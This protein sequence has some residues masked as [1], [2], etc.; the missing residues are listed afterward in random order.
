MIDV[1]DQEAVSCWF[2]LIEPCEGYLIHGC[3]GLAEF[4]VNSWPCGCGL[5]D[6]YSTWLCGPC[7]RKYVPGETTCGTC[8]EQTDTVTSLRREPG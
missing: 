8:H 2:E 5:L 6:R 4:M 7:L 3:H 1:N